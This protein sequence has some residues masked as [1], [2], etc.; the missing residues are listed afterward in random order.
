MANITPSVESLGRI[1][2]PDLIGMGDSEKL[3]FE[4]IIQIINIMDNISIYQ[5]FWIL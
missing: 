1:V 3:E 2:V 5:L 4:R